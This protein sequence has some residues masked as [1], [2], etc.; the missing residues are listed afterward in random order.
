MAEAGFDLGGDLRES[1]LVRDREIGEDLAVDVD[2]RAL[3]ARHE[4]RVG[5]AELSHCGVDA[6][7]PQRADDALL[8]P[9]VAVG[10][11]PC[12]HHRL[13][14]YA[15]DIL[16]AAAEALR[17]LQDLLVA[18]ARYG[19]SLDSRHGALLFPVRQH[20]QDLLPVGLVDRAGTAQLALPLGALLG[21]NVAHV[22]ARALDAAATAH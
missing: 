11:L 1:R 13:L 21:E 18:R 15:V 6:R 14:G 3:E 5:H 10:V 9:A 16:P 20:G 4:A 2:L 12:L 7:D 19:T 22:R 17:L 8:L